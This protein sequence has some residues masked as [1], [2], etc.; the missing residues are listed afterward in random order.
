[1]ANIKR[2]NR[3]GFLFQKKEKK[4]MEEKK[5]QW[6]DHATAQ[7]QAAWIEQQET[8]LQKGIAFHE[9][10]EQMIKT[11]IID[12][13]YTGLTYSGDY[14]LSESISS[15]KPLSSQEHLESL[16][17]NLERRIGLQED[18][19]AYMEGTIKKY[20]DLWEKQYNLEN[21]REYLKDDNYGLSL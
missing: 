11:N 1:M 3:S 8:V 14:I 13:S 18:K 17:H 6:I 20:K 5:K 19:I 21:V 4:V 16:I 15:R 2:D 9:Q 10:A 12:S 7:Q